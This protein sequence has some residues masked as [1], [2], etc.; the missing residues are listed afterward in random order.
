VAWRSVV[1]H[2]REKAE[3]TIMNMQGKKVIALASVMAFKERR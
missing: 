3:E 1:A 2:P